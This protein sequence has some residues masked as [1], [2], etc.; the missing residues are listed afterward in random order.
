MSREEQVFIEG[1]LSSEEMKDFVNEMDKTESFFKV[2]S[3]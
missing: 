1:K 3:S 2:S